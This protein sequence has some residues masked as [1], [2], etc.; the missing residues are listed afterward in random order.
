MR[1]WTQEWFDAMKVQS[2]KDE[3]Y[4]KKT[5]RFSTK[6]QVLLTNTPGTAGPDRR[7]ALLND[8]TFEKGKLIAGEITEKPMPADWRSMPFHDKKYLVRLVSSYDDYVKVMKS[9]VTPMN[10][11]AGGTLQ[12]VG[13]R[14]KVMAIMGELLAFIALLQSLSC[15][16]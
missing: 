10:A 5:K 4:M 16:Y 15:E 1:F 8:M 9:G 7:D 11:I 12:I 3:D 2:T 13:D 6:V 14:M